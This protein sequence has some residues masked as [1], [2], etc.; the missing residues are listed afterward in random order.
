MN[1]WFDVDK[2]LALD[3]FG[4]LVARYSEPVRAYHNLSHIEDV[5]TIFSREAQ[6]AVNGTVVRLALWY[7]DVIYDS[8][9]KNNEERSAEF[10]DKELAVLGVK[11][12]LRS[13]VFHLIMATRHKTPL[14]TPDEILITD[15]DLAILGGEPAAYFV[16]S[17][18][19]REEY[20]W[21]A[22]EVYREERIKVLQGFLK[23]GIYTS[24][25]F[26]EKYGERA[27]ENI[28][29]EIFNLQQA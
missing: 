19:I 10:A 29:H 4:R 8:R 14:T 21:V 27:K 16:Y 26:R 7:H 15:I 24:P 11:K 2:D 28:E 1:Q 23:R 17:H 5:L 18:A 9:A 6:L 22:P 12:S 13:E 3:A 25:Y 20:D